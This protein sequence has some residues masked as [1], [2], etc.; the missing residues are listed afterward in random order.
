MFDVD[1]DSRM[2]NIN[3][4]V[5]ESIL[6]S[7]QSQDPIFMESC[8]VYL[9]S[10]KYPPAYQ[11]IQLLRKKIGEMQEQQIMMQQAQSEAGI[12]GLAEQAMMQQGVGQSSPSEQEV[13]PIRQFERELDV[14]EGSL[15][16]ALSDEEQAST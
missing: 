2:L 16:N 3:L 12:L 8:M 6:K 1:R 11:Y 10:I 9:E 13:D 4:K 14:P 7:Q 15:D 5:D